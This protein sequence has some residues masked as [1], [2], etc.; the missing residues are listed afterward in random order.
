M[1]RPFKLLLTLVLLACAFPVGASASANDYVVYSCRLPDGRPAAVDGWAP[2]GYAPYVWF[3]NGCQGGG[4]LRAGLAGEYQPAN[5]STVGWSFDSGPA[6]IT[7][8]SIVRSGKIYGHTTG[9]SMFFYSSDLENSGV[10][11][12][13]VDYCTEYTGCT[14]V[15]GRLD[16]KGAQIPGGSHSWHVMVGCGG[17]SGVNCVP[18]AGAPE[19]GSLRVD[20]AAFTLSDPEHPEAEAATGSLTESG[21][22]SGDLSFVATDSISG[23]YRAAIEVDGAEVAASFPSANGG[24]CVKLGLAAGANDF[25]Y[26]RPCPLSQQVDLTLPAGAVPSGTHT[27]R[28]RVYDA[29]G[30]GFTAFG[31]RAVTVAGGSVAAASAAQFVPDAAGPIRAGYGA[32]VKLTGTLRGGTGQPLAGANVAA[33]LT[34]NAAAQGRDVHSAVTDERGRYAFV[35][36]ATASRAVVLTHAASG[37]TLDQSLTVRSTLKLRAAHK[38]VPPLGRMRLTGSIPGARAKRGASVAIKVRSGRGWRTVGVVRANTR[39]SFRFGYRFRRT[40][41]ARLSFRAVALRSGDLTVSPKPSRA[42]R[43]RVG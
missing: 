43:I 36:K 16:R 18:M 3:D 5:T 12:H 34:S 31:P 35:F 7:G 41:H 22:T 40:R 21:A 25:Q 26:R 27:V 24:R 19:F 2:T 38:H 14:S 4:A 6:E 9:A 32:V 10:G 11:G 8:Y 15:A 37:A 33:T 13:A 42:V 20:S 17:I 30:N 1:T 23:V 28:A 29:A 39:G